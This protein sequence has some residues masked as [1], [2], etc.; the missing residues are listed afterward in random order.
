MKPILGA[1]ELLLPSLAST[2]LA[3][4]GFAFAAQA[5]AS[6]ATLPGT[7]ALI[8]EGHVSSGGLDGSWHAV[9]DLAG[10][11]R[12]LTIDLGA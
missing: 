7:G 4:V 10:P 3:L 5:A 1:I 6:P 8:T 9:T 2:G 11:R 12:A